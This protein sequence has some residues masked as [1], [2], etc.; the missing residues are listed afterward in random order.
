[1]TS[2]VRIPSPPICAVN[3]DNSSLFK[4][5]STVPVKF[6]L[7]ASAVLQSSLFTN[8]NWRLCLCMKNMTLCLFALVAGISTAGCVT[9]AETDTAQV[10]DEAVAR[11]TTCTQTEACI[12]GYTWDSRS[13]ACVPAHTHVTCGPSLTCHGSDHCCAPTPTDETYYCAPATEACL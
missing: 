9:D 4:L 5:G 10:D 12:I 8:P 3:A 1:L 2:R 11:T 13:C 6:A 7:T